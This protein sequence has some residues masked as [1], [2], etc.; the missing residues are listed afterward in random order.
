MFHQTELLAANPLVELALVLALGFRALA[1]AFPVSRHRL[2]SKRN[3]SL[4]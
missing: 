4:L 1:V 3:A 2:F